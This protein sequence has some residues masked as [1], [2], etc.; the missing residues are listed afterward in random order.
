MTRTPV[1]VR[2]G[3]NLEPAERRVLHLI[4]RGYPNPKIASDVGI[5]EDTIKYQIRKIFKRLGAKDRCQAVALG[6]Q[7][8]YLRLQGEDY[9]T[10]KFVPFTEENDHEGETWRFWLQYTGNETEIEKLAVLL[11][12]LS[13]GNEDFPYKLDLND[14]LNEHDATVIVEHGQSGYMDYENLVPGTFACP[15]VENDE[16]DADI[17]YK[18]RITR[19]FTVES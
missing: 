19:Y 11:I 2:L 17:F 6:F 13:Y 7:Y 4:A 16:D 3:S 15:T 14:L 18:G 12:K 5:S 10:M 8:G 9:H 1:Q